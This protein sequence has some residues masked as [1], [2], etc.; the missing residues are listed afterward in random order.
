LHGTPL[1]FFLQVEGDMTVKCADC[2]YLGLRLIETR[3]L[4]DAD[5]LFRQRGYIQGG[6][7]THGADLRCSQ[8]PTCFARKRPFLAELGPGPNEAN[9]LAAIQQDITCDAFVE[10][11]PGVSPQELANMIY[12]EKMLKEQR[13]AIKKDAADNRWWRIV[14]LVVMGIL[15]TLVSVAAQIASA[16]IER[17]SLFPDSRPAQHVPIDSKAAN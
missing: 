16:F 5:E 8:C 11:Q 1:G 9:R 12:Q 14:E 2:G 10:W 3:A 6:L 17:G 13:E 15:V 7:G 4:V